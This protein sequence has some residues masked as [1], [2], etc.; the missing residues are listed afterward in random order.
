MFDEKY[1]LVYRI[2]LVVYPSA[3]LTKTR[4]L[5]T[6][7]YCLRHLPGVTD[8]ESAKVCTAHTEGVHL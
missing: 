7:I 5:L 4:H 2:L 3:K 1:Y 8:I 6:I